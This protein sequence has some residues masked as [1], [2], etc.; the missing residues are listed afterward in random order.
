MAVAIFAGWLIFLFIS[1]PRPANSTVTTWRA[2]DG[3]SWLIDNEG[4]SNNPDWQGLSGY[5]A[6][7]A[8][9]LEWIDG[10]TY[11]AYWNP[12]SYSYSYFF[13]ATRAEDKITF[14]SVPEKIARG[15]MPF[16][17]AVLAQYADSRESGSPTHPFVFP[18]KRP[19]PAVTPMLQ[20][21][22]ES[23]PIRRVEIKAAPQ[24]ISP[25]AVKLPEQPNVALKK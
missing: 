9:N 25:P 11:F 19:A 20:V 7:W 14:R 22:P 1:V 21:L 15:A 4:L 2:I 8:C 12:G 17:D 5:F 24:P 10:K 18:L 16:D 6:V 13:E 3:E 23:D